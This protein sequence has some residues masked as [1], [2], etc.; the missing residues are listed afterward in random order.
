VKLDLISLAKETLPGV[1][2]A[3]NWGQEIS[4]NLFESLIDEA[5]GNLNHK[6]RFCLHPNPN[7]PMQVTYIAFCAPYVDR[8]HNH[9]HREEVLVPIIGKAKH[10]TFDVAA[11]EIRSNIMD[12]VLPIPI[13]TP[14][15]IWHAIE[16][17]TPIF[18]MIEIG[19]GPFLEDSSVFLRNSG[20]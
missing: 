17:M 19:K 6:A 8:I 7:E 14:K 15:G 12:G 9:P 11:T 10:T 4:E 1:F 20:Q 16:V 13:S 5:K 2:H 18:V 3:Y